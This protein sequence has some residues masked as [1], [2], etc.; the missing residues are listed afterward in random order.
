MKMAKS[1]Y[2]FEISKSNIVFEKIKTYWQLSNKSLL[3]TK[4]DMVLEEFTK[5]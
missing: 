5:N 1:T 2:Y 4:V 3:K